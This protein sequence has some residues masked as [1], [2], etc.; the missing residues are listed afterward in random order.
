MNF[1]DLVTRLDLI[2]NAGLTLATVQAAE[3]EAEKK[4]KK[5]K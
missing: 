3:K 5:D 4:A 1:R 2:E